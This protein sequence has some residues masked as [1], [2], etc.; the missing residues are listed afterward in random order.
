[1]LGLAFYFGVGTK[2]DKG[3]GIIYLEDVVEHGNFELLMDMFFY[4]L[5]TDDNKIKILIV[6]GLNK[7]RTEMHE[8]SMALADFDGSNDKKLPVA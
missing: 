5:D 4:L 7:A 1:M 6:D 3:K 8:I 2:Q